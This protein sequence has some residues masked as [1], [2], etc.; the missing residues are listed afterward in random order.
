MQHEG[1]QIKQSMFQTGILGFFL[2]PWSCG[3]VVQFFEAA[4][5]MIHTTVH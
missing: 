3:G 2:L 1:D 4:A 5:R